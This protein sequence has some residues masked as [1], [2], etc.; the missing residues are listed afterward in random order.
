MCTGSLIKE[1]EFILHT[2]LPILQEK[3]CDHCNSY[4]SYAAQPIFTSC[5][6]EFG[7][8]PS[9]MQIAGTANGNLSIDTRIKF[10]DG[11]FCNMT[12]RIRTLTVSKDQE[13]LYLCSNLT[14]F[15]DQLCGNTKKFRVNQQQPCIQPD[16]NFCKYD[17]TLELLDLKPSD[18]GLYNVILDFEN[19]HLGRGSLMRQFNITFSN[20]LL[21]DGK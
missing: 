3:L 1:Y 4:P 19:E 20:G 2:S 15:S 14:T 11:G 12:K 17:M 10:V 16:I 7:V 21:N 13:Q 6:G 9:I 18:E 8:C 5:P